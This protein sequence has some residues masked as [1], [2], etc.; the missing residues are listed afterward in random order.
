MSLSDAELRAYLLGQ[1]SNADGER[2]EG[3]LV[4][5]EETFEVCRGV[6]DDLFDDF[7]GGRLS[8]VEREQFLERYGDQA[9][10]L[11]FAR[12]LA[13]RTASQPAGGSVMQRR[14]MPLA[15]AATLIMAA[16]GW[17]LVRERPRSAAPQNTV[18][19]V[20]VPA[21]IVAT[22][23]L[24]LGTSRSA[25][26]PSAVALPRDAS[27]VELRVRLDPADR[28]DRYVMELRSSA[29][30]VAWHADDLRATQAGA[31]LTLVGQA[32]ASALP[33][34][35]YELA[36]RGARPDGSLDPLGF[37]TLKVTRAP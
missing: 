18:Q 21:P 27:A 13:R 36:V 15:A 26:A 34:G 7:V 28:F 25:S 32:P 6:E 23:V 29:D 2:L 11:A 9:G 3:R 30:R 33:D 8:P 22:I 14:W 37:V 10:R 16:A 24:T 17:M 19:S 4:E 1:A 20:S 12:A 35:D 5:D 31:D